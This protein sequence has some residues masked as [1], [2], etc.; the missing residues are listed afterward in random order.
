MVIT[1]NDKQTD[2]KKVLKDVCLIS[3][4]ILELEWDNSFLQGLFDK[5]YK[6]LTYCLIMKKLSSF[7]TRVS[8]LELKAQ[9]IDLDC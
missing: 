1:N 6:L 8:S 3:A 9:S 5:N 7:H 4:R 2:M